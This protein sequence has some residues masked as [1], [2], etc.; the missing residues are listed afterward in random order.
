MKLHK[1]QLELTYTVLKETK[2]NLQDS[3]IRD[4]FLKPLGEAV[5]TFYK[6]RKEIYEKFCD[7]KE[8][9]TPDTDDG[10]Y[11]FNKEVTK[12]ADEELKTLVGEEV[13]VEEK[14]G[15]TKAKLK[16]LMEKTE[17]SPKVGET[18]V[19]DSILSQL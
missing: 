5:D 18:E 12:E 3:R 16:E 9:G 10:Q 1:G 19:I 17:Y 6:E 11:H 4:A 2:L 13:E 14:W 15:V 8:D 7:K